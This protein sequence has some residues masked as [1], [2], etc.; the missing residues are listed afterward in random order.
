MSKIIEEYP[1]THQFGNISIENIPES[2]F[3]EGDLGIR[4]AD[5]GRVWV[6]IN[7]VAFIRF[8]PV[9]SNIK[10]EKE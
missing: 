9:K 7:G 5:D 4:I 2:N 6:C 1:E 8:K 3:M 10:K